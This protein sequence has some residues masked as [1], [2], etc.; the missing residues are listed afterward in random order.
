MGEMLI[1]TGRTVAKILGIL[2]TILLP[3]LGALMIGQGGNPW[4][5]FGFGIPFMLLVFFTRKEL[6]FIVAI[7]AAVQLASGLASNNFRLVSAAASL[8]ACLG[9]IWIFRSRYGETLPPGDNRPTSRPTD[10]SGAP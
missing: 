4:F 2:A 3:P 6:R 5:A 7:A 9:V 8:L 1:V 10:F